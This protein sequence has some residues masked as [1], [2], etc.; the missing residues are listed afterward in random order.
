MLLQSD[1]GI[2]F[3]LNKLQYNGKAPMPENRNL[4][5]FET[6]LTL[7]KRGHKV[8]REIWGPTAYL[9]FIEGRPIFTL[10]DMQMAAC[11]LSWGDMQA[12]DWV[13]VTEETAAAIAK[14]A[15]DGE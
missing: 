15:E 3:I 11:N 2:A 13:L 12:N 8:R 5:G 7:L 6:A 4:L 10:V 9:S 1:T 14:D